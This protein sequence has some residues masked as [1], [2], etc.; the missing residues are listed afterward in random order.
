MYPEI[1][2]FNKIFKKMYILTSYPICML[3][4]VHFIR[5]IVRNIED[6]YKNFHDYQYFWNKW[7]NKETYIENPP[8]SITKNVGKVLLTEISSMISYSSVPQ[9][10]YFT[11]NLEPTCTRSP[12]K[13]SSQRLSILRIFSLVMQASSNMIL[14]N[15]S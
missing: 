12:Y 11:L 1:R 6:L 7:H 5:I 13:S 8:K 9:S 3:E 2:F 14:F 4:I 15:S 10:T